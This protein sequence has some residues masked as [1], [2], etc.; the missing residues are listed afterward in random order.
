MI[1]TCTIHHTHK[2]ICINIASEQ[3][4]HHFNQ[5]VFQLELEDCSREGMALD[6]ISYPNN[7]PILDM[8][9]EANEGLLALLDKE[10]QFSLATD[11][12]LARK[13]H[14]TFGSKEGKIYHVLPNKGTS[15]GITHY[16]GYVRQFI[17]SVFI[18]VVF[19]VRIYSHFI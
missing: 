3:L 7:R 4:Q 13:L 1:V 10:S 19:V 12:S 15:F 8:F 14:Q 5:H 16:T 17:I 11:E 9:L 2:Q 18:V 6:T